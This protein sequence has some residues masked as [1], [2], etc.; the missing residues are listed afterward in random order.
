LDDLNPATVG[1]L[2]QRMGTADTSIPLDDGRDATAAGAAHDLPVTHRVVGN[3]LVPLT[4]TQRLHQARQLAAGFSDPYAHEPLPQK[5]QHTAS[6]LQGRF[7]LAPTQRPATAS[8]LTKRHL[9]QMP[10]M[11]VFV[12]HHHVDKLFTPKES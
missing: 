10:H 8:G 9:I 1:E 7:R 4:T 6:R 3:A 2:V 5:H 12:E 11:N